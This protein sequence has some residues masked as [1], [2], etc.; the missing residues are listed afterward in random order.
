MGKR[1]DAFSSACLPTW[2]GDGYPLMQLLLSPSLFILHPYSSAPGLSSL[3]LY[4]TRFSCC[5]KVENYLNAIEILQLGRSND[6]FCARSG[7]MRR[8][9]FRNYET[10]DS[11][12]GAPPC[13][14]LRQTGSRAGI[15]PS[16]S[17]SQDE[18]L[19]KVRHCRC[20]TKAGLG[21]GC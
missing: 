18:A 8:V 4:L 15:P 6:S 3:L 20:G 17:R 5:R 2:L 21:R 10:N 7:L 1:Q 19:Y 11:L 12:D 16:D 13:H 9:R 14:H